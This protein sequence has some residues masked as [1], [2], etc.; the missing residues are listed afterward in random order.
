MASTGG[1]RTESK[2]GSMV[3]FYHEAQ[4]FMRRVAAF[5]SFTADP[6]TRAKLSTIAACTWQYCLPSRFALLMTAS[7]HTAP[8]SAFNTNGQDDRLLAIWAACLK[9]YKRPSWIF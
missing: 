5:E 2:S 7:P 6:I 8:S 3:D 9:Q 4:H 1:E